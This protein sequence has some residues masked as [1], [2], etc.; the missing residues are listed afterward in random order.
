MEVRSRKYYLLSQIGA[1]GKRVAVPPE[2]LVRR[3]RLPCLC[4]SFVE[5]ADRKLIKIDD[6]L[7]NVRKQFIV[8]IPAVFAAFRHEIAADRKS[9]ERFALATEAFPKRRKFKHGAFYNAND[10][11]R[12]S[13]RVA[14]I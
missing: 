14:A 12:S 10:G 9:A 5:F 2:L 13:E 8:R 3:V 6:T 11:R 4:F 1:I 7:I